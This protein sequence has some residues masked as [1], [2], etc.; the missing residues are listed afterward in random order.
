MV[1]N[2][3]L[4]RALIPFNKSLISKWL[5][6]HRPKQQKEIANLASELK[7]DPEATEMYDTLI[8]WAKAS[9]AYGSAVMQHKNIFHKADSKTLAKL[10]NDIG[11][12]VDVVEAA[13]RKYL[14]EKKVIA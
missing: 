1:Y 11:E 6:K 7:L 9:D 13:V 5:S 8:A 14:S 4:G 2:D 3:P 12:A 10:N